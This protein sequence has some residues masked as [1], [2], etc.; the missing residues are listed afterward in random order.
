MES[1]YWLIL[2]AVMIAI[3]IITLG[4]STI[5]FAIGALAAY[6][7]ALFG[8]D[9]V[10]QVIVFLAVSL[11][12]LFSTRPVAVRY[13]NNKDREKTNVD[14]MPGSTAKVIEQIDNFNAKGRVMLNGM[15]WMARS[16]DGSVIDAGETVTVKEVSGVKLICEKKAE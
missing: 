3:E 16:T 13:F 8:A 15:E 2:M 11:V 6:I 14:S 1:F 9:V 12:S 10:V 4:L 7:T 5:W